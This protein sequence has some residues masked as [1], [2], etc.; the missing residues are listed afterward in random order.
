MAQNSKNESKT[1]G[2]GAKSY[3]N[4]LFQFSELPLD[5]RSKEDRFQTLSL[6]IRAEDDKFLRKL[7]RK[8]NQPMWVILKSMIETYDAVQKKL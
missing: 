6:R 4:G 8:S 7:K 3:K 5:Y 1:H 2:L